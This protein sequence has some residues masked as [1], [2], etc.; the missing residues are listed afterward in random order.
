[1]SRWSIWPGWISSGASHGHTRYGRYTYHIISDISWKNNSIN[2]HTTWH[3]P[4]LDDERLVYKPHQRRNTIGI[5]RYIYAVKSTI[6]LTLKDRSSSIISELGI[7]CQ[8]KN[9]SILCATHSS[10]NWPKPIKHSNGKSL[11]NEG[12][13]AKIYKWMIF[14]AMFD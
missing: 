12:F 6:D 3:Q 4:W 7:W 14:I 9:L 10:Q 13:N 2:I 11:S 8:C 5:Y 1:M